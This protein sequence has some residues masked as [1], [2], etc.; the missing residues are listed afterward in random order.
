MASVPTVTPTTST[1]TAWRP[2]SAARRAGV[3]PSAVS[4]AE[5]PLTLGEATRQH[6]R[7]SHA[8]EKDRHDAERQGYAHRE[9]VVAE[10]RTD[11]FVD[12]LGFE[13][14]ERRIDGRN[15][16]PDVG[17]DIEARCLDAHDTCNE[18]RPVVDAKRLERQVHR[19]VARQLALAR[20]THHADDLAPCFG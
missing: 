5:F 11:P 10:R 7:E 4:N 3:A 8:S 20:I 18:R 19:V 16:L 1:P 17:P 14:D 9:D 12:V 13:H 15:R 2:T 6:R